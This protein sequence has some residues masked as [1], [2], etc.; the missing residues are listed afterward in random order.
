LSDRILAGRYELLQIIGRGGMG[1]VWL[2]RDELLHRQVA[3]KRLTIASPTQGDLD[4]MMREARTAARLN[5]AHIVAVHDLVVENGMPYVVTE[6]VPGTTLAELISRNPGG[7]PAERVAEIGAG[8]AAALREAHAAEILHRD[9]KPANI[10][11]SERGDAKLAD[12]GIARVLGDPGVTTTGALV[13]TPAFFPPEVARG[14][15]AAGAAADIWSLGMTLYVALEGR[16]PFQRSDSD[17][18]F[19]VLHRIANEPVPQPRHRGPVA[20]TIMDMLRHRPADRPP[21]AA[22]AAKLARAAAPSTAAVAPD[23]STVVRTPP[24]PVAVQATQRLASEKRAPKRRGRG[25]AIVTVGSVVAGGVT[26]AVLFVATRKGHD[27][28]GGGGTHSLSAST[29]TTV[30]VHDSSTGQT[31]QP[32]AVTAQYSAPGVLTVTAP[33]GWYQDES[34]NVPNIRDYVQPDSDRNGGTYFRIGIGTTKPASSIQEEE[35]AS[36]AFLRGS[37]SPYTQV[38][39]LDVAFETYLGADAV[40]IE[41]TGVNAAGIMRHVRE[42]LWHMNA[43][44]LEI[45]LNAAADAWGRWRTLFDDLVSSCQVS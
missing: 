42:R 25:A 34:A 22:V 14:E 16:S 6:Y 45:Q 20:T 13:G 32:T 10:L 24:D 38:Q 21:A 11:I 33:A 19:E 17:S 41:F 18:L 26:A 9:V 12:F 39:V 36:V 3:V 27:T 23:A 8:I 1:E 4:R 35:S 2:A 30:T 28:G 29:P 44:T 43:V 37:S 40:D 31:S 7:L 15:Q 5:H